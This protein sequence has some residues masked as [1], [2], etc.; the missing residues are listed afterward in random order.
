MES[1]ASIINERRSA[2]NFVEGIKIPMD[3][4]NKIFDLLRLAPSCHNLQHAHYLV[5]TDEDKKEQLRKAAYNQYKLHTASAAIIVLGDIEAHKKA[6]KIY[7]GLYNLGVYDK[8]EYKDILDGINGLY[9]GRGKGFQHEEAI[10]NASLSAMMFMLIAKDRGWDTCPM[11]GFEP[12]KVREIFNIPENLEPVL[13]I[14]MGKED[15]KK[16]RLRG[17]RKPIGEFVTHNS[18]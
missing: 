15:T 11:I 9:E 18:F 12:E 1:L 14:S 10:R 13:L 16:R 6:D 5:I 2:N 7:S 8:F 3:E 17:Y 4:F